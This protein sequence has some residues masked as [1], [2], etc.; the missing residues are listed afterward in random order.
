MKILHI[1]A[2]STALLLRPGIILAEDVNL[3]APVLEWSIYVLLIFA[4][5]VAIGIFFR[6]SKN[7]RNEPLSSVLAGKRAAVHSIDPDTSVTEC[8][9]QMNEQ[10]IGAMLVMK[11]E[12][13]VGIFTERDAMTKV[14][15]KGLDPTGTK[16]AAVMSPNPICVTPSTTLDEAMAIVSQQRFRHLPVVQDG[17]VL[18]MVSSG[19]LTH[20]LV[21]DKSG[22][23][24][25]LVDIAGRGG[26]DR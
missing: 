10:G 12:R 1:L 18:G 11:D 25:E 8:V 2:L 9:R 5:V 15:G 26:T 17:E 21:E 22:E 6:K 7:T 24:R 4:F 20:W 13:L 3:P 19:D 23:I 16:I 14:L